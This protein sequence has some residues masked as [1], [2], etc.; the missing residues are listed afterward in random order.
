MKKF[1]FWK[2]MVVKD[3]L[4][5]SL[6]DI[7]A[8]GRNL[9]GLRTWRWAR[10]GNRLIK[11]KKVNGG[12]VVIVL[13]APSIREQPLERLKG[14]DLVFVNQGFRLPVYKALH[15]KYHV[16]V[17]SKM[18]HGVWDVKWL[19]EIHE[20]V[21]DITFVMPAAWTRSRRIKPY[22]NK[23]YNI[24]WLGSATW[25]VRLGVSDVCFNL[26]RRLGY[27]KIYFTG[28]EASSFAASLLKQASHFYGNDMDESTMDASD[29]MKGYY[30]NARQMRELILH[31]KRFSKLGKDVVNLTRGGLLDMFR[32]ERFEDVFKG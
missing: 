27:D 4:L 7:L 23:G 2:W 12:E 28:F 21:P 29:Y 15:P 20:M 17:D 9:W 30:M 14:R 25:G 3:D 6:V 26:V 24:I 5:I 13:N 16:F 11:E 1:D 8:G 19:D 18:I 31:A 22:V 32:R 10:K